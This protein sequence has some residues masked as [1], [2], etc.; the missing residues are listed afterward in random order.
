MNRQGNGFT[1]IGDFFAQRS[2]KLSQLTAELKIETLFDVVV[3]ATNLSHAMDDWESRCMYLSMALMPCDVTSV[4][5]GQ[6]C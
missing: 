3:N 2:D 6:M 1:P 5:H 4:C